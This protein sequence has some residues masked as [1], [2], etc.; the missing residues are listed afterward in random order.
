MGGETTDR[1]DESDKIE[2]L[3]SVGDWGIPSWVPRLPRLAWLYIALTVADIV[4]EL[5]LRVARFESPG[6][7][8]LR[9]AFGVVTQALPIL[10][11]GAIVV[12]TGRDRLTLRDPLFAGAV[13]IAVN[14]LLGTGATVVRAQFYV[15]VAAEPGD[16][17]QVALVSTLRLL[18]TI[19]EFA[20]P[21]LLARAVLRHRRGPV[22]RWAIWAGVVAFVFAGVQVVYSLSSAYVSVAVFPSAVDDFGPEWIVGW[23]L[24]IAG[25]FTVLTWAYLA[26]AI[27]SVADEAPPRLAWVAGVGSMVARQVGAGLF[28]V[29]T[30]ASFGNILGQSTTGDVAVE[31]VFTFFNVLS[32]LYGVS[33]ILFTVAFSTGLGWPRAAEPDA[34]PVE[35]EPIPNPG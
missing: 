2:E 19:L 33:S 12:R 11:P 31:L 27:F 24:G 14:V 7:S 32:V 8:D 17:A 3:G 25:S 10:V 18:A 9:E 34:P 28:L 4:V 13:A 29:M 30:T 35:L 15:P 20:G 23:V 21:I 22:P 1:L 26:W 16:L 6:R 5:V